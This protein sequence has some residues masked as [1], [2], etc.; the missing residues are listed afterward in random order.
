MNDSVISLFMRATG[1]TQSEAR[2]LHENGFVAIEEIAYVPHQELQVA[3]NN[4][5]VRAD[6]I[7]MRARKWSLSNE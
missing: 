4:D 3:L 5:V 7:R 2:S 1:A 6:E